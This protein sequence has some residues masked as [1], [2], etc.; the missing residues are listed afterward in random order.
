MVNAPIHVAVTAQSVC[1]SCRIGKQRCDKSLPSC[2]RC[3]SK[4]LHCTYV[5]TVTPPLLLRRPC[6]LDLSDHIARDLLEAARADHSS[7]NL[8][9]LISSVFQSAQVT[10]ES[11]ID[12][13]FFT[14]HTWLPIID[15][16]HFR[17][18]LRFWP[19][20][21]DR[22]LATLVWSLLLVTR[23][24]C[25]DGKHSMNNSLYQTTRQLFVV[26]ISGAVT[27]ELLQA[28]L[29]ITY[30]A[31][32]HGL[33]REAYVT[34]TTCVTIA[35]LIGFDFAEM[36]DNSLDQSE[37]STCRWA[38]VL[39]DR[40]IALSSLTDPLPSVLPPHF[41]PHTDC[42]FSFLDSNEQK[43]SFDVSSRAALHLGIALSYANDPR[44]VRLAGSTY[45]DTY[46][47]TERLVRDL[48]CAPRTAPDSYTYCEGTSFA[49]SALLALQTASPSGEESQK[50]SKEV[51]LLQSTLRMIRENLRMSTYIL[52][53][54]STNGLSVLALCAL[55]RVAVIF[56]RLYISELTSQDFEMMR[57]N[58][59]R[60][61]TRW[62]V[63]RRYLEY[64]DEIVAC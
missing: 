21:N 60:F 55:S 49:V 57:S 15:E 19:Q 46:C 59:E 43:R 51:L 54:K 33:P 4:R 27:L 1:Q 52:Q 53:E 39:L 37:H 14:I 10:V 26:Q 41:G 24:P 62:A 22:P 3:A 23:W 47:R 61:A 58:L 6:C 35:Q 38:V 25:V 34:L 48:L 40:M 56:V 28:G 50:N 20:T 30:Y 45:S 2:S 36:S 64:I 17:S 12:D 29:L 16:E 5:G 8:S 7:S 18:R 44:P 42:L 31:C 13:Y 11:L 32:G 9:K 63:C